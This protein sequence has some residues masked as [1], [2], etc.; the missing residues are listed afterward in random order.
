LVAHIFYAV[1]TE[2]KKTGNEQRHL[3][4]DKNLSIY[5]DIGNGL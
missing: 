4:K 5:S 1:T 3:N 2:N